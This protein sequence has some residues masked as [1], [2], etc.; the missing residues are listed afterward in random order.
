MDLVRYFVRHWIARSAF[1]EGDDPGHVE[2]LPEPR[3]VCGG[4]GTGPAEG[5]LP[6]GSSLPVSGLT[7]WTC[8]S[9]DLVAGGVQQQHSHRRRLSGPGAPSREG[10]D[11]DREPPWL[12]VLGDPISAVLV[13][14][15]GSGTG[16]LPP[17]S[18]PTGRRTRTGPC[19]R[20]ASRSG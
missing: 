19:S 2:L 7:P 15:P 11:Q 4:A 17:P 3:D 20:G 10:G 1:L 9:L 8:T 6:G 18:P 14:V 13:P 12:S 16:T 5:F